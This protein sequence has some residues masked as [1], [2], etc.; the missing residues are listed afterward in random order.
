VADEGGRR[1]GNMVGRKL[2]YCYFA[3]PAHERR[4]VQNGINSP[5]WSPIQVDLPDFT[6]HSIAFRQYNFIH[7]W[8]NGQFPTVKTPEMGWPGGGPRLILRQMAERRRTS[9]QKAESGRARL[10]RSPPF[11]AHAAIEEPET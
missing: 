5:N 7:K 10:H 9:L 8:A 1:R 11:S 2:T 3:H 6:A 4:K